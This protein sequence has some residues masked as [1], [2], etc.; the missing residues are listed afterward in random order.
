MEDPFEREELEKMPFNLS[1]LR[2]ATERAINM[3]EKKDISDIFVALGNTG[4][5]K[6]TIISA[7][8]YGSENLE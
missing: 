6:S 3:L 5:G 4:S 2:E 7:L 1:T 8:L